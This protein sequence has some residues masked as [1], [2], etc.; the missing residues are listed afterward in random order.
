LGDSSAEFTSREQI[1]AI[2]EH[3]ESQMQQMKEN[4]EAVIG[5]LSE[6]NQ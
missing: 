1:E 6:E 4:Y 5:N 3:Y 2:K